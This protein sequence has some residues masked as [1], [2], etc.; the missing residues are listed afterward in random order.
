M[1]MRH[2]LILLAY[3]SKKR[4]VN[5]NLGASIF[6]I[7]IIVLV[8]DGTAIYKLTKVAQNLVDN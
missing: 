8:D 6:T 4:K 5:L 2:I 1:A 3:A 7:C